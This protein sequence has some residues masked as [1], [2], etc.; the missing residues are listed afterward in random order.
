MTFPTTTVQ[1]TL[2]DPDGTAIGGARLVFKLSHA[3]TDLATNT[4]IAQGVKTVITASDGTFTVDLWPNVNGA[5]ST[6]Y[7]VEA[8][9]NGQRLNYGKI[10]VPETG[11]VELATLLRTTIVVSKDVS[12]ELAASVLRAET[13][14]QEARNHAESVD[15][16]AVQ[17]QVDTYTNGAKA[18]SPVTP[19]LMD[20]T[21]KFVHFCGG[22]QNVT[23]DI[24]TAVSGP[25]FAQRS[26]AD[27]V[28]TATVVPYADFGAAG[29]PTGGD[30]AE[31]EGSDPSDV[32]FCALL[33][34]VTL[35]AGGAGELKLSQIYSRSLARFFGNAP[36]E[37]R[38]FAVVL[39][40]TGSAELEFGKN[41]AEVAIGAAAHGQGWKHYHTA[42]TDGSRYGEFRNSFHGEGRLKVAL[43]LPYLGMGDH[44][45]AKIWAGFGGHYHTGD[46]A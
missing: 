21:S 25:W 18:L 16:P 27:V 32:H 24:M 42:C 1:G 13:A 44:G 20:D 40:A 26:G 10:Q 11:P 2:R 12:A 6:H 19:N 7:D 46:V 4:A 34:D 36:A 17:A 3:D 14:A 35:P 29:I 37:T 23:Q 39:E 9:A 33:I 22:A 30:L 41:H 28:A 31:M 15:M 43:A 38:I 5:K 45:D 8:F